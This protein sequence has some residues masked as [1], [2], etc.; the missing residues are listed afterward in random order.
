MF[1]ICNLQAPWTQQN[2]TISIYV[3]TKSSWTIGKAWLFGVRTCQNS[4]ADVKKREPSSCGHRIVSIF[5]KHC[6]KM[7]ITLISKRPSREANFEVWQ[8]NSFEKFIICQSMNV[9]YVY[10][11]QWG[12][13]MHGSSRECVPLIMSMII[14]HLLI[15]FH[16]QAWYIGIKRNAVGL[17]W[18]AITGYVRLGIVSVKLGG[19]AVAECGYCSSTTSSSRVPKKKILCCL[20]L[21]STSL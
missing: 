4:I 16:K 10:L 12:Y 17:V 20:F 3:A 14:R 15:C 13:N 2:K 8:M 18:R 5:S 6:P 19:R 9:P 11:E 21:L 7:A 1:F